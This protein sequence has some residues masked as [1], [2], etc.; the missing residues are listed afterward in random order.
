MDTFSS[1]DIYWRLF[2]KNFWVKLH[3]KSLYIYNYSSL[4][5]SSFNERIRRPIFAKFKLLFQM[6][7][8]SLNCC[9]LFGQLMEFHGK[10]F[11]QK[12]GIITGTT[13]ATMIYSLAKISKKRWHIYSSK[14]CDTLCLTINTLQKWKNS[15]R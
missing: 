3:F 2:I 4:T 5:C 7:I 6:L 8:S 14:R 13:V 12:F 15:E 10:Y 11:Q 1:F 9:N